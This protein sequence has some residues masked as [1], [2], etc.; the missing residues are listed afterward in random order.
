LH[1]EQINPLANNLFSDA[2]LSAES[3]GRVNEQFRR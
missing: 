2:A 1:I 3:A